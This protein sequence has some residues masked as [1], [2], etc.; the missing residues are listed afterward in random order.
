M[1]KGNPDAIRMDALV[2]LAG[3]KFRQ[4]VISNNLQQFIIDG[5]WIVFVRLRILTPWALD[6]QTALERLGDTP[7]EDAWTSFFMHDTPT[8]DILT[9][10]VNNLP[11]VRLLLY[12]LA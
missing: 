2:I 6:Y 10:L 4:E 3:T 11:I 1:K 9:T 12:A 7:N 8:V 5:M